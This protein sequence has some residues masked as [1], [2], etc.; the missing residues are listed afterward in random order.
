MPPLPQVDRKQVPAD[1][2]RKLAAIQAQAAKAAAELPPGFLGQ[3][4]GGEEAPLDYFTAQQVRPP[5]VW[6]LRSHASE[7]R[8]RARLLLSAAGAR[9]TPM[10][11]HAMRPWTPA[12]TYPR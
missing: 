3:F 10:H 2:A 5:A 11:V 4:E 12:P 8:P 1:W 7:Q 9:C 6:A